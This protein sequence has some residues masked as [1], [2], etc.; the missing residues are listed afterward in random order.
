M[1]RTVLP[2]LAAAL[3]ALPA[4]GQ[5]DQGL[6]EVTLGVA[7]T[8]ALGGAMARRFRQV[9]GKS[10]ACGGARV[11]IRHSRKVTG[12]GGTVYDFFH[13]VVRT[14]PVRNVECARWIFRHGWL[15]PPGDP[16]DRG[17]G[18]LREGLAPEP[19]S[20][21]FHAISFMRSAEDAPYP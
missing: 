3:F 9:V 18:Y 19:R 14:W 8:Q 21:T 7:A 4:H 11:E 1:R 13:P 15:G 2:V 17:D 16:D 5:A 12:P 10:G 6:Y 20:R